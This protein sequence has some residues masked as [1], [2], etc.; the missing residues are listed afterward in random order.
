VVDLES[1][2]VQY[3]RLKDALLGQRNSF[4]SVTVGLADLVQFTSFSICSMEHQ[5][6]LELHIEISFLYE[7]AYKHH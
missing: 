6:L 7:R 2:L 4:F 3:N 5:L 1:K